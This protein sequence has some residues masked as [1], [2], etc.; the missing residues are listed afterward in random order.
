MTLCEECHMGAESH[1]WEA[2]D[3]DYVKKHKIPVNGA[4][5]ASGSESGP[6]LSCAVKS[7]RAPL[8]RI[9]DAVLTV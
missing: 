3:W 5:I 9:Q 4:H 2:I 8:S 1:Q 7:P 6:L